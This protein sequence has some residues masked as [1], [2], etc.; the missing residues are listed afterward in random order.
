MG[1]SKERPFIRVLFLKKAWL[2]LLHE[3]VQGLQLALF[4]VCLRIY[5]LSCGTFLQVSIIFRFLLIELFPPCDVVIILM[6][7]RLD[8]LCHAIVLS[9]LVSS[10]MSQLV[11]RIDEGSPGMIVRVEETVVVLMQGKPAHGGCLHYG[12]S[13]AVFV[14]H[15][16]KMTVEGQ[17]FK[18]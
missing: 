4:L 11:H 13:E 8:S 9:L 12:E 3:V 2:L 5:F 1:P 16:G 7:R 17:S 15:L 6:R 14:T 18:K 10:K